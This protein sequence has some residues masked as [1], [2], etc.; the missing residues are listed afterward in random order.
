MNINLAPESRVRVEAELSMD[1]KLTKVISGGQSGVDQAALRAARDL[2]IAIGGWCPPNRESESGEIPRDFPLI[3]TPHE[4]SE[5]APDIPRSLRTEWNVRDSDATLILRPERLT[6][7]DPGT[8][9]TAACALRY[10]RPT[11]SCDPG[12]SDAMDRIVSWAKRLEIATLNIGGPSEATAPGIGE[13][14]YDLLSVVFEE[15][16]THES[17]DDGVT[18]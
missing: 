12:D 5:L 15:L 18:E 14:A 7:I 3:E 17:R 1:A 4:R 16:S 13:Q 6:G 10:R 11:L 8:N 9:W 2:G